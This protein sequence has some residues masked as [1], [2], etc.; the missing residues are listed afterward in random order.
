M[1]APFNSLA[2]RILYKAVIVK[3]PKWMN[4][5]STTMR[6]LLSD[7]FLM[8]WPHILTLCLGVGNSFLNCQIE[9]N[10]CNQLSIYNL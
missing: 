3:N 2:Y 6:R 5:M 1:C 7:T 10:D 9:N 4:G 8:L